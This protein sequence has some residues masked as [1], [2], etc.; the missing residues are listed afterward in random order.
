MLWSLPAFAG[1]VLGCFLFALLLSFI[2][3]LRAHT[4]G[5]LLLIN[6]ISWLFLAVGDNA[7]RGAEDLGETLARIG[8]A[9]FVVFLLMLG[10]FKPRS[11]Q[12]VTA[13]KKGATESRRASLRQ[14]PKRAARLACFLRPPQLAK[15][16]GGPPSPK[17]QN[18]FLAAGAKSPASARR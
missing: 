13:K 5:N 3:G 8:L 10:I 17:D 15:L 14:N 2:P 12:R 4:T 6:I 11:A 18:R 7:V 1:T 9:Q 16:A